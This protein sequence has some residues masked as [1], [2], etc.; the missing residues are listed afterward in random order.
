MYSGEYDAFRVTSQYNNSVLKISF[1][2]KCVLRMLQMPFPGFKFKKFSVPLAQAAP[3][4]FFH[5]V[6]ATVFIVSDVSVTAVIHFCNY[7]TS[8]IRLCCIGSRKVRNNK[9]F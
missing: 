2:T 7:N 1:F 9:K 5:K 6:S 8:L 4:P 3:T